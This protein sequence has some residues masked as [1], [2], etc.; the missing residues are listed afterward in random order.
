MTPTGRVHADDVDLLLRS[1]MSVHTIAGR[2]GVK[3]GSV[4]RALRRQS[5]PDLAVRFERIA[6]EQVRVL[7]V[8]VPGRRHLT[9]C[10]KDAAPITTDPSAVPTDQRCHAKGCAEVYRAA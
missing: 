10:G 1:G 3:I 4:S 7:R 9:A 2:L 6:S 5:R 8:H